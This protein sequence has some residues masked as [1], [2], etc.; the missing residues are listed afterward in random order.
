MKRRVLRTA[1]RAHL[2]MVLL[3]AA[4]VAG[5]AAQYKRNHQNQI[6]NLVDGKA[7]AAIAFCDGFLEK[8]P[9]DLESHFILALAYTQKKDLA[10]AM[11]HVEKAVAGGLDLGRF[12]A[13]PRDLVAP[14]TGSDA[15]KAF[16]KRHPTPLLHGPM[17]GHVTDSAARVWVRTAEEAE[18]EVAVQPV[19]TREVVLP[20]V[21][22]GRTSADADYTAVLEVTHLAPA[23]AYRYTVSVDGKP[24]PTEGSGFRT[25]PKAGSPA[26]FDLIFGGGA[27]F[28]PKYEH[29]W[30][31]LADRKPLAMLWLGDN[32]YIDAPKMP[33]MQRY[34][35]YRRQSRPEFRRFV[36]ATANYSIYDDHDFGTNDCIPGPD[37]EDPPWKRQVWR[38][39]RANWANPSYGGGPGQP[40]CWYTFSIGDVDIFMLDCR[41]YRT[42]KSKPPTM[43]GPV[44]KAWLKAALKQ[45]K[46][47]FKILAS[48]VPWAY[49]AKPGSKDPWQGYKEERAEIFSFL[50]ANRIGGV[51]LISADRHRSDLWKIERPDG[52]ALYEFES[53]R[54]TNIHTHGIMKGCIYGYNKTCCFGLLGFDTTKQDPEVTYRIGTIDNKIVH[55]FTLKRSRLTHS[56]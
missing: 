38:I 32:V 25:F 34:C 6:K 36:A 13:G 22:K 45:S 41:Y 50:A 29:M 43:L 33:R 48:S 24:V 44:G 30:N 1:L 21:A 2:V 20:V 9:D 26:R 53:S 7:D 52:Y 56:R 46:G 16:A 31:T 28:T 37:I 14:L 10:K 42:L 19:Y 4:C 55:T 54:L 51:I 23:T 12:I 49:G 17:V 35:Y 47:T 3:A 18:V 39:F 11:G 8:H 15:F 40:G 27:G 5:A